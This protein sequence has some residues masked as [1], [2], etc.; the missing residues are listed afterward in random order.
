VKS[1]RAMTGLL[2]ALLGSEALAHPG[3]G[4]VV[5]E[6]GQVFFSDLSRG[7]VRIAADGK[8]TTIHREGGH[9]LALDS[10][11]RFATMD[12][13][14]SDHWPR[15]FKRRTAEGVK[16]ALLTDGGSPLVIG[17]DGN[18]YYV[19]DDEKMIPAGLQIARLSPD[20]TLALLNPKLRETSERL[21]G[22]KG[23]ACGPDGSL[24]A[25]Y[26][27][28]ILKISAQGQIA[29]LLDPVVVADCEPNVKQADLPFLKGVAVDARGQLYV[30]ASGCGCVIRIAADGKVATVLKTEKPWVPSGVAVQGDNLYVL[31]HI[32][33]NSLTHEDWPP[34]VRRVA[35]DGNTLTLFTEGK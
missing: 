28:S 25:T 13:A 4:I 20:G 7:L 29:T 22:I 3:S 12:F 17:H 23:L 27:K 34:R 15:W 30:A 33:G 31:E 5:D 6:Q 1:Y 11:G 9:W 2:I 26:P 18:L 8:A 14:L 21:G 32:N 16:P 10:Q 19:C 35:R 24:F